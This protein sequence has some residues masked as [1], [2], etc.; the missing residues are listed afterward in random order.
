MS[1]PALTTRHGSLLDARYFA[2]RIAT[3]CAWLDER[4]PHRA[5]WIPGRRLV[6]SAA[7]TGYG[8]GPEAVDWDARATWLD[9]W[10]DKKLSELAE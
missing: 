6:C 2:V 5:M 1:N 3:F 10:L 8:W 4:L 7:D 9:R